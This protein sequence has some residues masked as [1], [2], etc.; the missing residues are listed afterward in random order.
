MDLESPT[1]PVESSN[2]VD[3]QVVVVEKRLLHVENEK[4]TNSLRIHF[5]LI[6]GRSLGRQYNDL[7]YLVLDNFLLPLDRL[8]LGQQGKLSYRDFEDKFC[9]NNSIHRKV[10]HISLVTTNRRNASLYPLLLLPC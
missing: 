5:K 7:Y 3:A 6:E 1:L 2:I 9:R 4:D 8:G 10:V